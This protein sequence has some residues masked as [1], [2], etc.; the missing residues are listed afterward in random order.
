M[1]RRWYKR[2]NRWRI[3]ASLKQ[4]CVNTFPIKVHVHSRIF[5][6]LPM[7]TRSWERQV[8]HYLKIAEKHLELSIQITKQ[9]AAGTG[10]RKG[11][12]CLEINARSIMILRIKDNSLIHFQIYLMVPLYHQCHRNWRFTKRTKRTGITT[13]SLTSLQTNLNLFSIRKL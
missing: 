11:S 13:H 9:W 7:E 12:V 10:S 2:R 8:I 3:K 4:N 5:A 6:N 1:K